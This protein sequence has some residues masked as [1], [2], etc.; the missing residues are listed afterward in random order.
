MACC[1][2]FAQQGA[3][4]IITPKLHYK[5]PLYKL[6]YNSLDNTEFWGRCPDFSVNGVW[7]EHEGYNESKELESQKK[8]SDTFCNM[9]RRGVRQ[10][11]RIIV[12]DC[13]VGRFFAKR[14]IYNRIR[15]EHQNISEVYIRTSDSLELLYKKGEG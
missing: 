1:D 14:T 13:G 9:L 15:F 4:V 11:D 5:D 12:E 2:Y 7:Y 6:I 8:K 10:S 3:H